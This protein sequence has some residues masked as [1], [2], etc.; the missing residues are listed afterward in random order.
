[1]GV[2]S[3]V[4]DK[5]VDVVE[6]TSDRLFRRHH[7]V[8]IPDVA[9][10]A[11]A[12]AA[13]GFQLFCSLGA[14]FLISAENRHVR[15]A[16]CER[17]RYSPTQPAVPSRHNDVQSL[18]R[19]G[20]FHTGD[21]GVFDNVHVLHILRF[22][23]CSQASRHFDLPLQLHRAIERRLVG[24]IDIAD[25]AAIANNMHFGNQFDVLLRWRRL[26]SK[27][28]NNEVRLENLFLPLRVPNMDSFVVNRKDDMLAQARNLIALEKGDQHPPRDM[29]H[30]VGEAIVS[31]LLNDGDLAAAHRKCQ[32]RLATA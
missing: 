18:D 20:I 23:A 11:K 17:L 25:S 16:L 6:F 14:R 12:L 31:P 28:V 4:V 7:A 21:R 32:R 2:Y 8:E 30:P 13:E 26:Q 24:A 5:H 29:R 9:L 3:C 19:E 27:R 15:A 1:M 10:H 22:D